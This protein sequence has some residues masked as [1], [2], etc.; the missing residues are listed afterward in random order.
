MQ[1]LSLWS[2][3]GPAILYYEMLPGKDESDSWRPKL[4][5]WSARLFPENKGQPHIH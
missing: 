2:G 3:V 1:I 4:E 5:W